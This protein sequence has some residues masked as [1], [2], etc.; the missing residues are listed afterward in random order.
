MNDNN[1]KQS[2][3]PST[4]VEYGIGWMPEG[5]ARTDSQSAKMKL[6]DRLYRTPAVIVAGYFA[7][8]GLALCVF[9]FLLALI[10]G[11]RIY[12]D[13]DP[14]GE[15]IR[16]FGLMKGDTPVYGTVY[17]PDGEKGRVRPGRIRFSD[18][19][20]YEGH[21]DGLLFDGQGSLTDPDGNVY[22]GEFK[23]GLLEGEGTI[24]YADGSIFRGSFYNGKQD[25]YGEYTAEDGSTY[26]GYFADGEKSG[27][28]V[29]TYSD[30]SVYTGFFKDGMRHGEGSYRFASGDS[31]T[32][33]FRNNVIWGHGTYFFSSG[34][35]FTG[36]FVN[37]VPVTE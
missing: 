23:R 1:K 10:F 2:P 36:E 30:G 5:A 34:R 4:S 14:S 20:R 19:S 9:I 15:A 27:F 35:V 7:A 26:K 16:Y 3:T 37:G 24:E 11:L 18:G 33:E 17:L 22:K 32:G 12:K 25:G 6:S 29:L 8:A 13:T 21:M 31:Y 28:G